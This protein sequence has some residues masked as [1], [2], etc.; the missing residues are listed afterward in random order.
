MQ[1]HIGYDSD[2][3]NWVGGFGCLCLGCVDCESHGVDPSRLTNATTFICRQHGSNLALED[4]TDQFPK[5]LHQQ[6]GELLLLA[7][8]LGPNSGSYP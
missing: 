7:Q 4:W 8:H 2:V 1:A 5:G 6:R 3:A